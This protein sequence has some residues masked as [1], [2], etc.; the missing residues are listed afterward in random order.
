VI[1][2]HPGKTIMGKESLD[3]DVRPNPLGTYQILM[4]VPTLVPIIGTIALTP[5]AG[6]AL[7]VALGIPWHAPVR[8]HPNGL[9]WLVLFLAAFMVLIL[10]GMVL[11]FALSAA[12]LRFGLGWPWHR[13]RDAKVCPEWM[14]GL[15]AGRDRL[16]A[17]RDSLDPSE[18][19]MYD[20]DL[21]TLLESLDI[22]RTGERQGPSSAP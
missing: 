12:I 21:D 9:L 7:G 20:R 11:G 8:G 17:G 1:G 14:L 10:G 6:W 16:R 13:I 2:Q 3:E 22:T 4:L 5:I 19:S 15:L 18:D